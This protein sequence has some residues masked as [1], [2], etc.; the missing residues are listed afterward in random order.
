[1]RVVVVG[2][3]GRMGREV[4]RLIETQPDMV[5]AGGVE[6]SGHRLV[7]SALGLGTVTDELADCVAQAD[8]VVDFSTAQVA[9]ANCATT[10]RAKK[11]YVT[12][13]TGLSDEARS[14]LARCAALI[15]LVYASNFSLGASVLARLVTEATRLL[16]PGFDVGIVDTHHRAKKDAPSGTALR[17][18]EAVEQA[19]P[20]KEKGRGQIV[21]LRVGDVVGDHTVVFGGPGE[22]LE[23]THRATSRLAFASG[24]LAAV[25]FVV[26]RRPGFYTMEDVLSRA[27]PV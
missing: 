21:S 6:E 22:R 27:A 20:Q 8:C 3:G 19:G 17:L 10:A 18:L 16:G 7:G 23:L 4:C 2:C 5:L 13:V 1:M 9:A 26:E 11:P 24:V 25:R 14:V 12:G 15:P